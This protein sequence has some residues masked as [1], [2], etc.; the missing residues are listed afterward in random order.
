M[1]TKPNVAREGKVTFNPR[2][3]GGKKLGGGLILVTTPEGEGT[4]GGFRER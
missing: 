3:R 1:K 4:E 2:R